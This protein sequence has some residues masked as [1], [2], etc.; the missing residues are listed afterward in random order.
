MNKKIIYKRNEFREICEAET[1]C[2]AA[3]ISGT[4][5]VPGETPL[6]RALPITGMNLLSYAVN[7]C[8]ALRLSFVAA[9]NCQQS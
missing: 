3:V 7:T 1:H 9:S 2:Y 4:E 8:I 6:F 5:A